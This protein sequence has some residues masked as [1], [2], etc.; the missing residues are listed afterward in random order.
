MQR[1]KG[2]MKEK[3]KIQASIEIT[4]SINAFRKKMSSSGISANKAAQVFDDTNLPEQE[5][6]ILKPLLEFR[7]ASKRAVTAKRLGAFLP[8][9]WA[10]YLSKRWPA[11]WLPKWE[12][13]I[14][15]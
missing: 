12:K 15:L 8:Y 7:E 4:E 9:S 1:N 13:V 10:T 5:L 3:T 2:A 6:S 14:G 11:R